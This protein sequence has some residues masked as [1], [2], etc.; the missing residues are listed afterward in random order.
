MVKIDFEVV[1]RENGY[2]NPRSA[3]N[4]LY[5]MKK[6]AVISRNAKVTK[7]KPVP[8]KGD[9]VSGKMTQG[10]IESMDCNGNGRQEQ[11]EKGIQKEQE[12]KEG[13]E[14]RE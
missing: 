13:M 10:G 9:K 7:R 11:E 4:K 14:E 3:S 2:S 6:N 8:R 12:Q 1:A 5:A